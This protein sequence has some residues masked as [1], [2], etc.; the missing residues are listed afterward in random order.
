MIFAFC[1]EDEIRRRGELHRGRSGNDKRLGRANERKSEL[2][3]VAGIRL[4]GE[5]GLWC[6]LRSRSRSSTRKFARV[7]IS[8]SIRSDVCR[9]G[10]RGM[11]A[12]AERVRGGLALVIDILRRE[13]I[14]FDVR[15]AFL[16]HPKHNLS[17][18]VARRLRFA[19]AKLRFAE[20][21]RL[22]P[23]LRLARTRPDPNRG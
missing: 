3:S 10:S 11:N 23:G 1:G 4:G 9:Q 8:V 7:S 21:L 17:N 5:Q 12:W 14:I 13:C 20:C 16:S 2:S 19:F 15:R 22:R 18:N 6:V